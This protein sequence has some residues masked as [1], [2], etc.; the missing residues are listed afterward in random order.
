ML[1]GAT[2]AILVCPQGSA[3]RQIL[4]E[5]R[6]QVAKAKSIRV[7]VVNLVEEFPK[8]A[9]TR[10]WYR[11]EG[12]Y[13]YESAQGTFIASPEKCWSY[14]STGKSYKVFPGAEKTWSLSK[15]IGLGDF[16]DPA[17]MPTIGTPKAVVWHGKSALRVEVDGRK[18]MTKETKLYYYFD[19]KSHDQ[20]GVSANLGSM[21]QVAIF[22]DLKIDQKLDE[23]TFHFVPP[24]GWKLVKDLDPDL[25]VGAFMLPT[26][27]PRGSS[28]VGDILSRPVFHA[29]S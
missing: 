29:R 8:P 23:S 27:A 1:I 6:D 10:W 11:P 16:G 19:P 15:Q 2:V 4:D 3:S 5:F 28:G 21:T 17:M 18:T 26:H 22:S 20:L 14:R 24:K 13:R 12:Y 7:T 9:Q 25:W